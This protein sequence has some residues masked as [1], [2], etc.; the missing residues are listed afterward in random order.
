[1]E[2]QVCPNTDDRCRNKGE[3]K[4]QET[5]AEANV[6]C[7]LKAGIMKS[8]HRW[9][10]WLQMARLEKI[11]AGLVSRRTLRKFPGFGSRVLCEVGVL[12]S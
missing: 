1:M 7:S 5:V 8:E 9:K 12:V 11:A 10:G 6:C 3:G 4:R 2:V